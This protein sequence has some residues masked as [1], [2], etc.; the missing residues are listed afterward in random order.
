MQQ[1]NS[2]EEINRRIMERNKCYFVLIPLF[3]SRLY[4]VLIRS[5]ILY[6][7]KPW[8]STLS[9]EKRLLV[10]ERKILRRIYGSKRNEEENAYEP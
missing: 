1:A 6:A 9:G 4:K 5:M 7:C 10:F 2:H 3:K 8:S